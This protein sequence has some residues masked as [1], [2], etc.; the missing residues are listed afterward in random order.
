MEISIENCKLCKTVTA[1][2]AKEEYGFVIEG[3]MAFLFD[4]GCAMAI[5]GYN[6][7]EEYWQ[8]DVAVNDDGKTWQFVE[9][10]INKALAK[11]KYVADMMVA[12][13]KFLNH[14]KV[15]TKDIDY[16][17]VLN[18]AFEGCTGVTT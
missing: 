6:C 17:G 3:P 13:T 12:Y 18:L 10:D 1:K 4:L 11:A 15:A 14:D 16:I 9:P 2:E 5:L 8:L 7:M